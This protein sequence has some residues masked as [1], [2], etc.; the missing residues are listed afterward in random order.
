[1]QWNVNEFENWEELRPYVDTA[2]LPLYLYRDGIEVKEH[3]LRMNYLLNVAAGIEQRLKGRI[4]LFPL[5][6]RFAWEEQE[7]KTPPGFAFSVGLHFSGDKIRLGDQGEAST[8]M[9]PVGEE[10]LDSSLRFEV[11]VDVLTKEIIRLWQQKSAQ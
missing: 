4:L 8:L 11:T 9:L 2:L 3:V 7:Q 10:D 5:S 1:M 6:Y